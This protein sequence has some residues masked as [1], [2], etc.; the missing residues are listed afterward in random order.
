MKRNLLSSAVGVAC[1]LAYLPSPAEDINLFALQYAASSAPNVLI[2]LDN[3]SNWSSSSQAW[4]MSSVLTKCGSDTVCKG[5][6]E[7]IFGTNSSLTQGQV[8]VGALKAVLNKLVCQATNPINI[9]VGLMLL[10]PN[11][12]TYS[13]QD[14]SRTDNSGVSGVIRRKVIKL[15]KGT[16]SCTNLIGDFDTLYNNITSTTYK[17]ASN[18]NYGGAMF[19]AFKYFGGYQS[20]SGTSTPT[21]HIGFGNKTFLNYSGNPIADSGA[22][23][24]ATKSY[25]SPAMN[26]SN[27]ACSASNYLLVVGNSWPDMDTPAGGT[28]DPANLGY[29]YSAGAFC[30]VN[31]RGGQRVGDVWSKFLAN[32]DV[33]GTSAGT[34]SIYTHTINVY[35]ASADVN[36]TSLLKSMASNG[37]GTYFEV[38]GDLGKLIDSFEGFFTSIATV[39]TAFSSASLPV[40]VNTQG[41]YLNQVFIGMFRPTSTQRWPG[42]LKQYKMAYVGGTLKL[43]DATGTSAVDNTTGFINSTARSYWS[44]TSDASSY[45]TGMSWP[46]GMAN[47]GGDKDYPDGNVVEKGGQSYK[48]RAMTPASRSSNLKTCAN[49]DCSSLSAFSGVSTSLVSSTD[50]QWAI[51]YNLD[52][53]LDKATTVMRPSAHGDIVHSRPVAI[54]FGNDTNSKQVV[55]FYGGNDGIFRAI[56]GNRGED[57]SLNTS[58]N[59]SGVTPGNELWSFMAPEYYGL[60]DDLRANSAISFSPTDPGKNYGMDGPVSAYKIDASNAW[61]YAGM[62][63]GGRSLYGFKFNI[64]T[65]TSPTASWKITNSSTG[66][67]QLGQTWSSPRIIVSSEYTSAKLVMGGGYDTCEDYDNGTVNNNCSAP[68]GNRIYVIDPTNGARLGELT[69]NRSVVGEVT[70]VMKNGLPEFGYVADTG[71]YLYRIHGAT[72]TTPIGNSAVAAWNITPIAALGCS[73][74]GTCNKNR[75]F[76]FA[77]DVVEDGGTYYILI[78]SGDRE[79]P[80]DGY[81]ATLGV[82]NHFFMVKDKPSDNAWLSSENATCS[83][84]IICMDSLSPSTSIDDTKKGWYLALSTSEQVVTGAITLYGTVTFSTHTPSSSAGACSAGLGT[85]RVYNI[86]YLSAANKNGTNVLGEIVSGGGLPPS[87]VAGLVTL[88]NLQTVPFIIGSKPSGGFE[89]GEGVGPS[90]VTFTQPKGRVYWYIQ[91]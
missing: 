36:Q 73:A 16:D 32:A 87:P 48:L 76:L 26:D 78:G 21:G 23:N 4:S 66:Y 10:A 57:D 6:V 38:G 46:S 53:E 64:S 41:T 34:N 5:Y 60:I 15:E 49:T 81:A 25:N 24:S 20:P 1:L 86:A 29:T 13:R 27:D 62:R 63:R 91:Q 14:G 40:S 7:S 88:D 47:A 45:W 90:S 89:A 9:N 71:G 70:M 72:A 28:Y 42:N 22:V 39:N 68:T 51:G 33:S 84:D 85:T 8:E 54:N 55:V 52:A 44:P 17:A 11:K 77:P 69:T 12:G 2:F 35:N 79:K 83:S 59:I 37:K 67:G 80:T 18:A 58:P 65:P 50:N 61:V 3:T 43:V 56:N 19:E 31:A 74:V 75:K 82:Q 30:C